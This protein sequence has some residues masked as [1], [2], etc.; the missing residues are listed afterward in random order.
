MPCSQTTLV[1]LCRDGET[2]RF[3]VRLSDGRTFAE[4]LRPDGGAGRVLLHGGFITGPAG[5]PLGF[6]R[7]VP[8]TGAPLPTPPNL[9]ADP[10]LHTIAT[11]Q[12]L[13]PAYAISETGT[14]TVDGY[15]TDHLSLRPLRKPDL[16]PLRD[17]WVD[18]TTSQV[19]RL[20][21]ERPF[22]NRRAVVQYDFAPVG[23][24]PVWTIVHIAAAAGTDTVS[25]YLHDIRFPSQEPNADFE[26]P[27]PGKP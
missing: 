25:Q 15:L 19:V 4:V 14:E 1:R 2:L 17:V 18:R 5:A 20:T 12:A 11:V 9:A 21:Y 24:P 27:D 6:F 10:L 3:T 23:T 26:T 7:S 8:T 22:D 13:N 16:Y